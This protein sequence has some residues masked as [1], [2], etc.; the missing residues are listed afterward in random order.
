MT[1]GPPAS[2]RSLTS[3]FAQNNAPDGQVVSPV[4]FIRKL[5]ASSNLTAKQCFYCMGLPEHVRVSAPYLFNFR[6]ARIHFRRR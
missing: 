3:K 1:C 4:S 6:M 5:Y 2:S